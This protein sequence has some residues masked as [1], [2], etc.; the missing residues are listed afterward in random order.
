[1]RDGIITIGTMTSE[2]CPELKFFVDFD[3]HNEGSGSP[4]KT[5]KEAEEHLKYLIEEHKKEY[6]IKIIDKRIKQKTLF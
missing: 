5:E 4:F 6:K 2:S 1:M 3:G